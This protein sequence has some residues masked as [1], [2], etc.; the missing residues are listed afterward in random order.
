[1]SVWKLARLMPTWALLLTTPKGVELE[2][3][4]DSCYLDLIFFAWALRAR[5]PATAKQFIDK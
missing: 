5:I 1:M 4:L 2:N 3:K